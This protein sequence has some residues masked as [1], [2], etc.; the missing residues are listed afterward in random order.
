[1]YVISYILKSSLIAARLMTRG[2]LPDTFEQDFA[3]V[4]EIIDVNG[5]TNVYQDIIAEYNGLY[6]PLKLRDVA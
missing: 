2:N 5:H 4:I 1:M 6:L 3:L